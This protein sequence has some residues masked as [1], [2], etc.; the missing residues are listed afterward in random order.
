MLSRLPG[1]AF[2]DYVRTVLSDPDVVSGI[3]ASDPVA[4]ANA[5]S[6]VVYRLYGDAPPDRLFATLR[7]FGVRVHKRG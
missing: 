3:G 6:A 2:P 7:Y 1:H 5:I 4:A